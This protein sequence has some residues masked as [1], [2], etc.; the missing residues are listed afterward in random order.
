MYVI[1][2]VQAWLFNIRLLVL[3]IIVN[4]HDS[5]DNEVEKRYNNLREDIITLEKI[6]QSTKLIAASKVIAVSKVIVELSVCRALNIQG[7]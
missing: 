5:N 6:L 1:S 2:D 4:T 7:I 3:N